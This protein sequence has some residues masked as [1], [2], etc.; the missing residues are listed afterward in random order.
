[1][2]KDKTQGK[3]FLTLHREIKCLQMVIIEVQTILHST[4]T[5]EKYPNEEVQTLL[6][7]I[8]NQK[9]R[10]IQTLLHL[11]NG[12]YIKSNPLIFCNDVIRDEN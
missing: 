10:R 6:N 4:K 8:K 1:M 3:L 12:N 2:T 5:Q 11:T 9:W 7:L